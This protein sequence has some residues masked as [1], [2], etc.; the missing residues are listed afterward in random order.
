ML[1]HVKKGLVLIGYDKPNRYTW[2]IL[3]GFLESDTDLMKLYDFKF[4]PFQLY[5]IEAH[6]R[7]LGQLNLQNYEF[8]VL[9]FSLLSIQRE[10]FQINIRRSLDIMKKYH[11]KIYTILGGPEI[12][13]RYREYLTNFADFLVVGEGERAFQHI[14]KG[15]HSSTNSYSEISSMNGL[16]VPKKGE[17][18]TV[19]A[20]FADFGQ[21]PSYSEKF[22]IFSPI[23]I[24]RGCPFRCKFC[25][26][27]SSHKGMRH[28]PLD[29][30]VQFITRVAE[31][32]FDKIWFLTPNAFAYG[33]KNGITPNPSV[34]ESLLQQI[35]QIPK[36]K[37]IYLGTFPS[38]VR[39]ES[40]SR[41][42]L[43]AVTPYISNRKILI[44][45]QTASNRLLK[46]IARGHSIEDVQNAITLLNEFNF[47]TELDFIFGLP[48]E[49]EDDI[50]LNIAFFQDVLD[51]KIPNVKIHTHTFMPLPGTSFESEP[52][53]KVSS[54]LEE[55]IGKLAKSGKAYGEYQ[56]QAGKVKTRYSKNK[57]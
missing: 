32:K 31:I 26:T 51:N 14:L 8:V 13:A 49:T 12:S 24:S 56:A 46:H 39:P 21:Y 42:V 2:S 43:E 29:R 22:R 50:A 15:L 35:K 36:I 54:D 7:D 55:I 48:G 28:V 34:L 1:I 47:S 3:M 11:A 44:G 9:A 20:L 16:I 4:L 25:Q 53:G 6:I 38:E 10:N 27:G 45:A 37:E 41:E 33:S 30:L 17:K 19:P 52:I 23:E 5:Q 57:N 40:V 18:K